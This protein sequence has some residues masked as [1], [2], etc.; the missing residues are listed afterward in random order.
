[1][2]SRYTFGWYFFLFSR[3]Q[4]ESHSPF[5]FRLKDLFRPAVLL[6]KVFHSGALAMLAQ[7]VGITKDS[8]HSQNDGGHL[9][10]THKRVQAPGEKGLGRQ[11]AADAQ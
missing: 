1:M 4:L 5:Q 6:E 11:A 2:W 9:V 8:R 3:I 10:P 7:N